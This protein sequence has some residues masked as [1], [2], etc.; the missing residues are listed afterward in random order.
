VSSCGENR[1]AEQSKHSDIR[2]EVDNGFDFQTTRK[3]LKISGIFIT[4][5]HLNQAV[6]IATIPPDMHPEA[7]PKF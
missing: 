7:G 5:Q 1:C 4:K 3:I 6:G 2:S